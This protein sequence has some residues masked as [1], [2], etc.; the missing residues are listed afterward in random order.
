MSRRHA[1]PPLTDQCSPQV[2]AEVDVLK[3]AAAR[4]ERTQRVERRWKAVVK[5]AEIAVAEG[6]WAPPQPRAS[7][8]QARVL[9]QGGVMALAPS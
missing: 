8:L 9:V 6:R 5:T 3:A 2:D 7:L 4:R 1:S